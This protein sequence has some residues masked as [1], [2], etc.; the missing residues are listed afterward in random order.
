MWRLSYSLQQLFSC[1]LGS[2]TQ[3]TLVYLSFALFACALLWGGFT[4]FIYLGIPVHHLVY[5]NPDEVSMWELACGNS[6]TLGTYFC[7]GSGVIFQYLSATFLMLSPFYAYII[8]SLLAFAGILVYAGFKTGYFETRL[9]VRP[10]AIVLAFFVSVWLI[11]TT[12][13][14]GTL[15][16]LRSPEGVKLTDVGGQRV[17]PSF[18]R[19]FEPLQQVYGGAGSQALAELKANYDS[20]LQ[21]GCLADTGIATQNGARLY[22]LSFFCMQASFFTRAGVQM[23]MVTL[24]LLNFLVLGRLLLVHV[25]KLKPDQLLQVTCYSLGIGALAW[26]AILWTLGVFASLNTTLVRVLFFGMPLLLYPQTL[27]WAKQGMQK[28]VE[29]DLSYKNWH[30]LL[31]WMLMSYLALN[32]LNVVRP[33]PI[34]WDDLGSYLN[35]PRLLA[36]YGHFIPSMSQFQWEYLTSLGFLLFGYDSWVGSTF[37]MQVNWAAGLIAVL[38]VYAF[39]RRFFGKGRGV[40]A[41]ILYY[42]LP[43]TGH[44]SFADMKIDNASFFT[45]ALAALALLSFAFPP[46]DEHGHETQRDTKLLVI[47][48]LLAGFS[49]AIKPTAILGIVMLASI[50]SGALLGWIGFTGA[51]IGGFGILQKF[52]AINTADIMNRT[53]FYLG[54]SADVLTMAVLLVGVGVVAYALYTHRSIVRPYFQSLGLFALGLGISVA[55][56]IINN[57]AIARGYNVTAYMAAE[58]KEAYAKIAANRKP[59]HVNVGTMLTALD[60]TAPQVFYSQ[61]EEVEAM[62]LASTVPVRYLPPELTVDPNHPA[63]KSSARAEELDRY[64]GFGSGWSHYVTLAWRQVMNIDSFGYYVTLVPALLLLPLLLLLPYFWSKEGRWLRLLTVG[65]FIFFVQW[66]FA[67][68]GVPWYGIGMF[69][70]FAIGLEAFM[71]Y[72]P[73]KPN[74]Y[75]F[76]F[77]IAMSI[78]ICITNRLWQF[79]SQKNLFEYPLGKITASALREVT[80]PA[81]DD[82]RESMVSRHETMP[83]TPYTYRIGTFISYFIPRNRDIFPMADHQLNFFNCINQE[84]NH[85]LTLKRLQAL[86]FNGM[87][88]DTNTYTIEKNPNG[89][90]HQKVNAFL[91]FANDPVV[92]MEI[93]VNDPDN[94]VAYMLLPTATGSTMSK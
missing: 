76:G 65:T 28:S 61:K 51:I 34:G 7:R 53:G 23:I 41:A 21:N 80:I 58:D 78:M 24:L 22:N 5:A 81:Y 54:F 40:L 43:M 6:A 60:T 66:A 57:I 17:L 72:A 86:G 45:T 56:W 50:V 39:G 82:I 87:I 67:A 68:N 42:F 94:G 4:L 89:P 8:V 55:P 64:W 47:A 14:V 32:F 27:W 75:I 93:V 91:N 84:R 90:L 63:C 13:S 38:V 71:V 15:Y 52:G 88:F 44:F 37:A 30:T 31:V 19:F 46:K 16:N 1:T 29:V 11:A 48:G 20:L 18:R 70:G 62:G 10:L 36:S 49:F 33:F 83:D 79:D 26:V 59:G 77:L 92:H 73:D 25:M 3:R 2:M 85:A 74:R 9:H 12:F 35:R 69:L